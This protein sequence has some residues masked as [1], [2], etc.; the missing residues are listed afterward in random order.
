VVFGSLIILSVKKMANQHQPD[1]IL[2]IDALRHDYID[3]ERTP[4]LHT[5]KESATRATVIESFSFQTRPAYFAGLEPEESNICNL[6]EYN[7]ELSPFSFLSPFAPLTRLLDKTGLDCYCRGVI[8]RTAKR[9]AMSL[10]HPAAAAVMGVEKIPLELLPYFALSEKQHTDNPKEFGDRKT[11]FDLLRDKNKSWAWIGYPRHFGST[12]SILKAFQ[13]H[14]DTD[15]AYLHFSELDWTGHRYG[16]NSPELDRN[17]SAIDKTVEELV[18]PALDQ[19]RTVSIFGDHG[20]VEVEYSI[21][22]LSTLNTLKFS[23]PDDYLYFLDST[24]AR[25]WFFNEKAK[26]AVVESLQNVSG[27]HVL[28]LAEKKALKINFKDNRYGDSIFAVDGPGIIHPS[29]FGNGAT[30]PKG[31]HGYLPTIEDNKTQILV[32]GSDVSAEDL[33]T[34]PMVD[35][36]HLLCKAHC[37]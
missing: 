6:Y 12:P 21:D 10:G 25:F 16:P 14:Q 26:E 4:F 28:S 30:G 31:M 15:I 27:G 37:R 8:R 22:L 1:F 19:G 32:S 29:F 34:I 20:M 18:S 2:L 11:I 17:L 13:E 24:Q 33:G 35:I 9:R 5:L 7:R 36:F 3:A 23:V